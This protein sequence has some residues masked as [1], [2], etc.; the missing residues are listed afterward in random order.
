MPA[1][2]QIGDG[3]TFALADLLRR[4]NEIQAMANGGR[5]AEAEAA[6]RAVI[7]AAPDMPEAVAVQ[8]FLLG[9]LHRVEEARAHLE[10]AIAARGD[11]PHWHLELAQSYRRTLRLD[12]AL[13]RSREA[14]RLDPNDSR[15][16][17]GLAR[18][19]VDRGDNDA[20]REA[21]LAAL[22]VAPDDVEA[23]LAQAHLLLA[24]GEYRAAWEEYEWR[25]RAPRFQTA[26]PR[27]T[28]P[29]WN[30]MRLPGRRILVAADQGFGDA[31]QFCRYLPLVAERCAGVVVL[32]RAA[33]VAL[34]SRIPGVEACVVSINDVGPHA[35][36]CWMGS[37]P[38]LFGTTLTNIPGG[39]AYLSPEPR[40]KAI[41]RDRLAPLSPAGS[42]RVGVVWAGN[43]EN[44]MDWRRSV[45]LSLLARLASI[46]RLALVS[47]QV[48]APEADRATMA[49]MGLLD[50]SAELTD[51]QETA[52]LIANLDLVVSVDSA[53]AHL[54]AAMGVP[55]WV[56][57]YR[58][59]DWRWLIG[60][61]DS[62]W[63]PSVRLFRQ[64]TPGDWTTPV[65][66]LIEALGG[67]V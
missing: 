41:W 67:P 26:M 65:G 39:R 19:L 15:F 27:F 6:C 37:L 50:V 23:H 60:R 53:V 16:H 52:S 36:W 61:E 58:P 38:R 55:T 3:K 57:V 13:A 5:L 59:A 21:L 44:S 9:R 49:A 31:F 8:G 46:E 66:R 7:A 35:V 42:V 29:V 4:L 14:V 64:D 62:P 34:F 47:L 12:D 1:A 43:P 32:C 18:V 25:F 28:A 63:Y 51:F 56:L 24:E 17:L 33:Q 48:Q 30:G 2:I 10:A 22:A 20:A 45:P 40:R 54:A 11:V